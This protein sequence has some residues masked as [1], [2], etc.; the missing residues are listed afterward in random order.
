MGAL[1]KMATKFVNF[2]H[3]HFIFAISFEQITN[4]EF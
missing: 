1:L 4:F 3:D 2:C